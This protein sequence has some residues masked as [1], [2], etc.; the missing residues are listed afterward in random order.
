VA[1]LR[2]A[3]GDSDGAM[4]LLEEIISQRTRDTTIAKIATIQEKGGKVSIE[5]LAGL[6]YDPTFRDQVMREAIVKEASR[7]GIDVA[8]SSI[9]R[10]ET[11]TARKIEV[12]RSRINSSFQ[13]IK[14]VELNIRGE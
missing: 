4:S 5:V 7:L 12:N 10:I 8:S 14:R 11:D 13:K 3:M 1:G 6:I 9:D 2:A